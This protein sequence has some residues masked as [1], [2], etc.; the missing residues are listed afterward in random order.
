ML[1]EDAAVD[2]THQSAAARRGGGSSSG[3]GGRL[4]ARAS[5]GATTSSPEPAE[6]LTLGGA[7]GAKAVA[8]RLVERDLSSDDEVKAARRVRVGVGV[9]VSGQGQD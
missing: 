6:R 3:G 1:A 7:G 4:W 2:V 8:E 5:P 9:K